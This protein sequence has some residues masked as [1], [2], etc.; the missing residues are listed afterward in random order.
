MRRELLVPY[1]ISAG[2]AALFTLALPPLTAL[3]ILIIGTL[4]GSFAYRAV[5]AAGNDSL[6]VRGVIAGGAC[7][8]LLGTLIAFVRGG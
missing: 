2:I 8:L 6:G 5:R 4:I 7:G 1:A 3:T